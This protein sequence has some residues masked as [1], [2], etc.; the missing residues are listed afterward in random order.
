MRFKI[1]TALLFLI[2]IGI[3]Y[4][5]LTLPFITD[6]AVYKEFI[7]GYAPLIYKGLSILMLL[8][9]AYIASLFV[10]LVLTKAF[11][12]VIRS[13]A[14]AKKIFPLIDGA[15]TIAI[16]IMTALYVLSALGI[17]INALITG[18]GI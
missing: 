7:N 11:A 5:A 15:I 13:N 2:I 6:T 18:A 10:S 8:V 17:N 9:S 4:T 3:A 1:A 14:L 16:W 12:P